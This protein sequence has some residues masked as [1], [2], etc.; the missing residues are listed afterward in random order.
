MEM[1]KEFFVGDGWSPASEILSGGCSPEWFYKEKAYPTDKKKQVYLD[2]HAFNLPLASQSIVFRWIIPTKPNLYHSEWEVP[3]DYRMAS[4][5]R[6][7]TGEWFGLTEQDLKEVREG[8]S[9]MSKD[10]LA[11]ISEMLQKSFLFNGLKIPYI[12]VRWDIV[13]DD[14]LNSFITFHSGKT[15]EQAVL[16]ANTLKS[17]Q[18]NQK[19]QLLQNVQSTIKSKPNYLSILRDVVAEKISVETAIQMTD[20]SGVFQKGI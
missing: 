19:Q 15:A 17:A 10:K 4:V 11:I 2:N 14:D 16:I 13:S 7:T 9:T 1:T 18:E 5:M 20:N 6:L 12:E 8:R 3:S